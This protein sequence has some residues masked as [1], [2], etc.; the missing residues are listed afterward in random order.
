[1]K[2]K[3]IKYWEVTVHFLARASE[4]KPLS[5]EKND[6]MEEAKNQILSMSPEIWDVEVSIK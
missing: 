6:I 1:M 4:G 5:K 2:E 3:T